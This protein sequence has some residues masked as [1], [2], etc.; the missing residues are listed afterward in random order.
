VKRVLLLLL[1]F[2]ISVQALAKPKAKGASKIVASLDKDLIDFGAQPFSDQG[3]HFVLKHLA[4]GGFSAWELSSASAFGNQAAA[5]HPAKKLFDFHIELETFKEGTIFF[6]K[7]VSL[8]TE[9]GPRWS[10]EKAME[11]GATAES[12]LALPETDAMVLAANFTNRSKKPIK[13][14]P[15]LVISGGMDNFDTTALFDPKSSVLSLTLDR[16]KLVQRKFK[17]V[18]CLMA[19]S[20]KSEARFSGGAAARGE[21]LNDVPQVSLGTFNVE[22]GPKAYTTLNPGQAL[23][24]PVALHVAP[25][26]KQARLPMTRLWTRWALPKGEAMSKAKARWL[27]SAAHLPHA[28]DPK[29]ERLSRRAAATLLMSQYA[30]RL[31]LKSDM[32]SQAKGYADAFFSDGLPMAA[33]GLSELDHGLAESAVLELSSFSAAAPSPIP[34]YTGEELLLWEA[35]GLP[36]HGW[37]AWELYQRD[38][39]LGRAGAF[40]AGMGARLRNECA[41]W[42]ANRDGDGNGLY[43]YAKEEEKPRSV[44]APAGEA[45]GVQTYSVALSSF[46]AWQMQMASALADAAGD[47]KEAQVLMAESLK[48]AQSLKKEARDAKGVYAQGL[49]GYLP[50]FLGLDTELASARLAM[51][52]LLQQAALPLPFLEKGE[53]NPGKAYLMLRT[54]ALYGYQEEA[55]AAAEKILAFLEDKPCFSAY[56]SSGKGTGFPGDAAT[57][58]AVLEMTLERYTQDAYLWPDTTVLKGGLLSVKTSDGAFYLKRVGLSPAKAAYSPLSLSVTADGFLLTAEK[59][60]RVSLSS[61]WA[62]QVTD[63]K[64]KQDIFKNTK[65]ADMILRPRLVYA[66]KIEKH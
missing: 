17:E 29:F 33:L 27:V 21:E 26:E 50:Y 60:T 9:Y 55:H 13:V 39:E 19:G 3:S 2:F 11:P 62:L 37:A 24:F 4:G 10:I 48:I 58:G 35:A 54:L 22:L 49:D 38:P 36:M 28:V 51:Q 47:S 32:L 40:L 18:V 57:A 45:V 7:P 65:R 59:E 14:R 44:A 34:P 43:A 15:R 20:G 30:R 16:S 42:P 64:A 53:F 25:D 66:V 23:R 5:P 12:G 6:A 56:D 1:V 31:E 46:V 8:T 41:W 63:L 61:K 52:G